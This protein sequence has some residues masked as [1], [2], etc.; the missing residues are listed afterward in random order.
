[1]LKDPARRTGLNDIDATKDVAVFII[2]SGGKK[3]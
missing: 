2:Q 3:V 1:M